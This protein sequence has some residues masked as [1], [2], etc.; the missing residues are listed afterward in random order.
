M[1]FLKIS[2]RKYSGNIHDCQ[3]DKAG[4]YG[5]GLSIVK[6]IIEK[7]GGKVGVESTGEKGAGSLFYFKLPAVRVDALTEVR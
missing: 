1:E 4:G 7:L 5:L 3:P 6:R 2:T